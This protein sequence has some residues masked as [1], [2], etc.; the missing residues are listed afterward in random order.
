L[1]IVK[2]ITNGFT[3]TDILQ[4]RLF[5]HSIFYIIATV[6]EK[7][8]P[9]LLLPVMVAYL[10]TSDY[11]I[12]QNYIGLQQ[13]LMAFVGFSAMGAIG[14]TFY[15]KS[16]EENAEYIFNFLLLGVIS[17][18]VLSVVILIFHNTI[19]HNYKL[20][21][22]W[23]M[24]TILHA[25]LAFNFILFTGILRLEKKPVAYGITS[26]L[27]TLVEFLVSIY[28]I[29]IIG[30]KWEGRIIGML[31]AFGIFCLAS[32][33]HLYKKGYIIPKIR[34]KCLIDLFVFGLPLIPFTLS[35]MIRIFLDKG[36]ITHFQGISENGI[37]G[38]AM[39][40]GMLM[41][42]I[43]FAFSSTFSPTIYEKL[44][45]PRPNTKK[46]LVRIIYIYCIGL[47]G[48]V[49]ILS[50]L[51]K[52]FIVKFI[53]PEW[54]PAI[55][56]IFWILLAFAFSG[57]QG[58]VSQF[59][60]YAKRTKVLATIS[61]VNNLAH[62]ILSYF[63]IQWIGTIGVIYVFCFSAFAGLVVTWFVSAKVYPMPWQLRL[64]RKI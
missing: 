12:L 21:I 46:T 64:N 7:A 62:I 4:N 30:M 18:V 6:I 50:F 11:G 57:V 51:S 43:T 17:V 2:K 59:I 47:I 26:I 19:S 3:A 29:V 9:F 10:S 53:K 32:I 61:V 42:V 39:N 31:V 40:F 63:F 52:Y 27:K 24:L 33:Y 1:G 22:K 41:Y 58:I 35:Q 13:I 55:P 56:Y 37:V 49:F 48:M 28:L 44:S 38:L 60:Y 34:K 15:K 14:V 23:Q 5:R 8:I 45:K 20:P 25:Y 54:S 16:K 36:F